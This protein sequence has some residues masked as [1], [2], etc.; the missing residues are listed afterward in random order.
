MDFTAEVS[1]VKRSSPPVSTHGEIVSELNLSAESRGPSDVS[2]ELRA[3]RK[4]LEDLA[5]S[6]LD[7]LFCKRVE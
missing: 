5:S 6:R 1:V 2:V 3:V 7:T 4:I